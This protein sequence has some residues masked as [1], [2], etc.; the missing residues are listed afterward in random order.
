MNARRRAPAGVTDRVKFVRGDFY[1]TDFS[2]SSIVMMHLFE[3]TN[4]KLKPFLAV[5]ASTVAAEA[6]RLATG[7]SIGYYGAH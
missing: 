4:E 6:N 7:L 3:K 1:E 2:D 5:S